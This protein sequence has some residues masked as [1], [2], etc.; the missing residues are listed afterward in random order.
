LSSVLAPE[1]LTLIVNVGD[2][3]FVYGVHVA[4]DLDTV[5]YTLAGIE[6]PHGWGIADDTFQVMDEMAI[7]GVDASFR[8]GDRDLA[9]CLYRTD[10]L[11]KG[12]P[13]TTITTQLAG[14]IGVGCHILPASNDPV[15]TMVGLVDGSWLTFQDYFVR[16]RHRDPVAKLDFVGAANSRPAPGVLEA[17]AS[18]DLLVVAPSNPPLSIWPILEIPGIRNAVRD[19]EKV[20]AVSPLFGGKALKGPAEQVIASLGLPPGTPGVLAAYDGLLAVLVV[21]Q[22]DATDE[23]LSTPSTRI[24]AHDTRLAE[25]AQG[26]AFASWLIDTMAP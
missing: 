9:T 2:D 14:S 11:N 3:D 20:V 12:V 22:A 24:V 1:R 13:L 15:R 19:A 18:A 25:P 26:R 7:R 16:R 8:L 17:I 10:L 23:G 4:A 6:G 21:D 5:T